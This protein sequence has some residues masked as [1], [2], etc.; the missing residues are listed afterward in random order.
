M[1]REVYV[2]L[3]FLIN[4]CMDLLGLLLTAILLH[5]RIRRWRAVASA[6]LGGLYAVASLLLLGGGMLGFA[7][8][9][10]TALIMVL[11]ALPPGK[12]AGAWKKTTRV[13]KNSAVY[14]LVS[15][16]LGGVMTALYSLLNRLELP[17]D[18]LQGEGPSAFLFALLTLISGLITVKG[19]RFL[20][21][22]QKTRSVTLHITMFEKN[23]TLS[24][25][26]DT[27][28]LLRDPVSGRG[29]IVAELKSLAHVLPRGL[30][31]AIKT[32]DYTKWLSSH[33]N[34][35]ITRLIPTKTANG[36]SL[37]LAVIPRHLTVDTGKEVYDA[38]YLIA[39]T[40]LGDSANG[41]EALIGTD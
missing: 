25:L 8:D 36:E 20:G 26:V 31:E 33:Q 28:N 40:P 7:A 30:E 9:C 2:D 32:G 16:I 23:V 3:Y 37:L 4:A 27:G 22:S 18:A 29:V 13:L 12:E 11:I 21:I 19:G 34:S 17:L 1:E 5:R 6:C 39:P 10:L 24:A 35:R 15:M 38:D 41:F 14:A